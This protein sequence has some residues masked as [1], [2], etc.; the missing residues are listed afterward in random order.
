[1]VAGWPGDITF[2]D[3]DAKFI[4]MICTGF[5]SRIPIWTECISSVPTRNPYESGTPSIPQSTI[6]LETSSTGGLWHWLL[7]HIIL[8]KQQIHLCLLN[9]NPYLVLEIQ[10]C[11]PSMFGGFS[12]NSGQQCYAVLGQR[13]GEVWSFGALLKFF[14]L[15]LLVMHATLSTTSKEAPRKP[16]D[17]VWG[18][19]S[20]ISGKGLS[21]APL[22]SKCMEKN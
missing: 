13:L 4:P 19:G 1:M 8:L 15:P 2:F 18:L 14:I 9:L 10:H 12:R 16:G 7:L 3:L 17:R 11:C 21:E 22:S 20:G 6:L 5:L